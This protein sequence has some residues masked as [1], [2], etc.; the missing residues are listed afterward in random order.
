MFA[1]LSKALDFFVLAASDCPLGTSY[2]I[3]FI[4][5]IKTLN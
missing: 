3:G 4:N 2:K 5:I 1:C